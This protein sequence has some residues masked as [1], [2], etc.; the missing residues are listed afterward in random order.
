MNPQKTNIQPITVTSNHTLHDNNWT[1]KKDTNILFKL[2]Y[3][4]T[5][6][7]FNRQPADFIITSLNIEDN[8]ITQNGQA[9]CMLC[10]TKSTVSKLGNVTNCN[11]SCP[12]HN[13][14]EILK[15]NSYF[16]INQEG[17][18]IKYGLYVA[19]SLIPP[20]FNV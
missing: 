10:H 11:S 4:L 14:V 19:P 6:F 5:N 9:Y 3:H 13:A 20:I 1:W 2:K 7:L 15:N 12:N 16:T 17:V 18:A 8:K